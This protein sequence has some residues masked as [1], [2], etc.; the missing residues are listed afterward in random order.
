LFEQP[1]TATLS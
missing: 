1:S